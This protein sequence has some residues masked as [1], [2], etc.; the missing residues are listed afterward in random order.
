K[1]VTRER[2]GDHHF[3]RSCLVA[4]RLVEAGV[5]LVTVAWPITKETPH[6]DT[7]ANHFPAMKNQL[8]PTMDQGVSALLED[9]H[10]RGLLDDTLV[11]CTGEFGRT[12]HVDSNAKGGG[13]HHWGSVYSTLLAGGGVRGGA[14]YG[15]SDHLGAQPKDHPVHVSDFVATIYHALGHGR[16]TLVFDFEGR[17]HYIVHGHPVTALFG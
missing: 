6:F 5:R 12:P 4:R 17:P 2:Y 3:G 10:D 7:H 13:R 9:L 11:V 16:D 14:V 15:S 1:Q 8:L